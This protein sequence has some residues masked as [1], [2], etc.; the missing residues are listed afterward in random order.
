MQPGVGGTGLEGHVVPPVSRELGEWR[1]SAREQITDRSYAL[2]V[3]TEINL[4]GEILNAGPN[5]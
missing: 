2:R 5:R 4:K 1:H 3:R